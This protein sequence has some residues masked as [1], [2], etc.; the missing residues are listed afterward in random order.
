MK[1]WITLLGILL[2]IAVADSIIQRRKSARLQA[3]ISQLHSLTNESATLRFELDRFRV[4][5]DRLRRDIEIRPDRADSGPMSTEYV[6]KENW[7]HSGYATPADTLQ[8]WLWSISRADIDTYI[9]SV[10][11]AQ[12]EQLK[13]EIQESG[14]EQ[15][16]SR[17][18]KTSASFKGFRLTERTV[19]NDNQILLTVAVDSDE[20]E[21]TQQFVF[22]RMDGE[23]KLGPKPG[24]GLRGPRRQ[25]PQQE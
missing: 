21:Q 24:R 20:G 15:Y 9:G 2:C 13:A 14:R 6:P 23:W 4:E 7:T 10:T 22:T 11:K 18:L 16:A 12:G 8:T 19:I 1:G 17:M 25:R 5:N 3:E